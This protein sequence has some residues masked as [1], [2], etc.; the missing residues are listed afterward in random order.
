MGKIWF[1]T[2]ATLA[3]VSGTSFSFAADYVPPSTAVSKI[4]SY[5]G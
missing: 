1:G 3:L 2:V 4:N 5:R